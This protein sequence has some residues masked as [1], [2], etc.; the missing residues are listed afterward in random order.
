MNRFGAH[1]NRQ[2][3][4]QGNGPT[5]RREQDL[6]A[7]RVENHRAEKGHERDGN[8]RTDGL[9]GARGDPPVDPPERLRKQCSRR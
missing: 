1:S 4:S 9:N 7:P 3:A 8:D 6:K 2:Q 5:E